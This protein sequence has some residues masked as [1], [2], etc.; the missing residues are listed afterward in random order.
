MGLDQ[1]KNFDA[2]KG[3]E[4]AYLEPGLTPSMPLLVKESDERGLV[5]LSHKSAQNA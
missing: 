4:W 2:A 1:E 3:L 5:R